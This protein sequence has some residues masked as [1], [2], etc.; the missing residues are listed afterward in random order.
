MRK[1]GLFFILVLSISLKGYAQIDLD[2]ID[3]RDLVGKVMKV[4]KGFE[5]KFYLGNTPVQKIEKVAEI[6]GLKKNEDVNR[7][8]RTYRTGR[9]V[10]RVAAI[11]GGAVAAYG[12]VRKLGANTPQNW[13]SALYSGLGAAG[14]GIVIKLLTRKAAYEAV[15]IFNQTAIRKV[16]DIFSMEPASQGAGIALIVKL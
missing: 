3:L 14:A 4:E 16:I 11:G 5:P 2:Q 1:A 10:Y 7:L 9:T 13:E 15:D 12:I 6:L 8:F